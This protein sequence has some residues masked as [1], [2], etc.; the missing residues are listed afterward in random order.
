MKAIQLFIALLLTSL[1]INAQTEES[2]YPENDSFAIEIPDTFT[3][4]EMKDVWAAVSNEVPPT[5]KVSYNNFFVKSDILLCPKLK[6]EEQKLLRDFG[7]WIVK[8]GVSAEDQP[9][10]TPYLVRIDYPQDSLLAKKIF[11]KL[12]KLY[13][14]DKFGIPTKWITGNIYFISGAVMYMNTPVAR[15]S[16]VFKL[17]EGKMMARFGRMAKGNYRKEVDGNFLK[18][19]GHWVD[20]NIKYEL[21]LFAHDMNQDRDFRKRGRGKENSFGASVLLY[22]EPTGKASIHLLETYGEL[23]NIQKKELEKLQEKVK[24]LP[25]WR[26][27]VLYN[28]DGRVF[29]GRY[30]LISYAE[31]SGWKFRDYLLEK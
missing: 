24:T 7:V 19:D 29:P 12:A 4:K 21:L 26:F 5:T 30:L 28:A 11:N 27:S 2:Y 9:V 20:N 31:S 23:T 10:R 13:G 25:P 18:L 17:K 1:S 8:N 16:Q 15:Y 6:K 22:I 3:L 14:Q